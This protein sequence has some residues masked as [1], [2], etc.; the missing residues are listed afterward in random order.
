M[1]P[2]SHFLG[3]RCKYQDI[4]QKATNLGLDSNDCVSDSTIILHN[5]KNTVF[6]TY[7]KNNYQYASLNINFREIC[8]LMYEKKNLD[9][10]VQ[11]NLFVGYYS[12]EQEIIVD[13][14]LVEFVDEM[15]TQNKIIFFN[16]D[17]DEYCIDREEECNHSTHGVCA[18]LVPI[19]NTYHL[20]YMNPHGEVMKE[21]QEYEIFL[22]SSR[23]K[24]LNF[25]N[26]F[27]DCVVMEG[28][29]NSLQNILNIPIKYDNS[30]AHNYFSV[31]LQE[32]DNHGT[33]FIFPSVIY[34]YFGMYYNHTKK[35][36]NNDSHVTIPTFNS[37]LYNN[38][39]NL[40]II[41]C[42]IDFD[43]NY[44]DQVFNIIKNDIDLTLATENLIESLEKSKH[45]FLKNIINT[46]TN[47][48][49]Q[50]IFSP[51]IEI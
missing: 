42:F 41:S 14:T 44:K 12:E 35:I 1:L 30:P 13:D 25:K 27:V 47:F 38:N 19:N 4:F 29:V 34:Y 17:A 9:K 15:S 36:Y 49:D 2:L 40:A 16:I 23:S 50:P 6:P 45:R 48:I 7:M 10:Y 5:L 8:E 37:L 26:N 28:I 21:Y 24:R 22:S 43:K 33:C 46:M 51:T 11:D 20:Y 39:F 32:H 3:K 31:N 18:L